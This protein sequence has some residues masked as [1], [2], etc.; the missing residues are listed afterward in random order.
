LGL[1]LQLFGQASG[2]QINWNKST[3]YWFSI[4][5]APPWLANFDFPWAIERNVSK[6]LGTPF[7]L[8]LDTQD[9]DA[10]FLEKVNNKLRYWMNVQF[11]LVGQAT[12]VMAPS[13]LVL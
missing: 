2:L 3:A 4:E 5:P 9:I 13:D 8:K 10:F 6:L 1:L 11:S 12:I 7:G